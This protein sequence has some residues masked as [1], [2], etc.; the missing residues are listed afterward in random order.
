ME[1]KIYSIKLFFFSVKHV[2]LMKVLFSF[3]K[4]LIEAMAPAL[5]ELSVQFPLEHEP[6]ISAR[7]RI[8]KSFSRFGS[9]WKRQRGIGRSHL[10]SGTEEEQGGKP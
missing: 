8:G 4:V 7:I 6:V 10:L 2:K 1:I 3:L 9:W 5:P